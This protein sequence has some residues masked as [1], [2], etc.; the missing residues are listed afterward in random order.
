MNG[1]HCWSI[2]ERRFAKNAIPDEKIGVVSPRAFTKYDP[3][4]EPDPKYFREILENS[5]SEVEI[6]EFCEHFLK[7]LNFNKK[8]YKDKVPCLIGDA[9]SG[10]TSLFQPILGLVHHTN[11]ATITK[12]RVFNKAMITKS[13]EVIFIDEASTST[14]DIDD[15]KILT[16][17]GF[18]ECDV[19]YQTA[20]SFINRYP[21]LLT[22]QHKL[23]F[24]PED[25]PAMDRRLRNYTFRSLPAPKKS[26][27]KWLQRHPMECI[28]WAA[29]Q[30]TRCTTSATEEELSDEDSDE[31]DVL[32]AAEKE[33][34]RTLCLDKV[35]ELDERD[36]PTPIVGLTAQD[37]LEDSEVDSDSSQTIS[38]LRRVVG[39]CT[40]RSLRHRQVSVML[41]AQ[42]AE[43]E[44]KRQAEEMVYQERQESLLSKGVIREHAALLPRDPSEPMPTQINDDLAAFRQQTLREE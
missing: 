22:A 19:K 14:M 17:G 11:I 10:K 37:S 20:K 36:D 40:Q 32:G 4:I 5:L 43:R 3:D 18:T 28:A 42:L 6:G 44:R 8:C 16:Q 33:E 35:L 29:E 41:K 21:M 39:Q 30:A 1:G 34:L 2:R 38:A 25:Q 24:K 31:D 13:T 27:A 9:N 15:W 26:A 12:Q 23:E 7:L